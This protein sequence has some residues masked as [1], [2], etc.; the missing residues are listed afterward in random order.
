MPD[1]QDVN[2]YILKNKLDETDA[3]VIGEIKWNDNK[4]YVTFKNYVDLEA[5]YLKGI[6]EYMEGL[7]YVD[8]PQPNSAFSEIPTAIPPQMP[9][10]SGIGALAEMFG[11]MGGGMMPPMGDFSTEEPIETETI[12]EN[13]EENKDDKD[14]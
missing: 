5:D 2:R 7:E 9:N 4:F 1:E 3:I 12:E 6:A 13:K 11:G 10:M 14:N 8:L